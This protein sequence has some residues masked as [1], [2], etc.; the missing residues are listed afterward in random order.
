MKKNFCFVL[1]F[2]FSFTLFCEG[3]RFSIE[4]FYGIKS[5]TLY[6][7]A[8]SVLSN[9]SNYK[10][11]QLEWHYKPAYLMGGT[12]C[13]AF[14]PLEFST[15]VLGLNH[16]RNGKLYDWDYENYDGKPTKFSEHRAE[17]SSS[18]EASGNIAFRFNF[19][20][21][22]SV[23]PY[24]GLSYNHMQWDAY[25]GYTQYA[26]GNG[27]WNKDL[28][29]NPI[30]G[31]V[32]SYSNTMWYPSAGVKVQTSIFNFISIQAGFS[33]APYIAANSTDQHWLRNLEFVD[34]M[35]QGYGFFGDIKIDVS[36]LRYHTI[37]I[38][39]S[40]QTIQGVKGKSEMRQIGASGQGLENGRGGTANTNYSFGFS[41]KLTID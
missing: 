6:E 17:L 7:Y 40:G 19:D 28:P 9:K 3:Y 12:I 1:F 18:L 30:F 41:Y 34:S 13:S 21:N 22:F 16:I 4:P 35:R 8:Y 10:L 29:K 37:S 15:T 24:A 11:S 38:F 36:F 25:D 31:K 2:S 20:E 33:A 39:A 14:G 32:I 23:A 26:Q 27:Y 5:G